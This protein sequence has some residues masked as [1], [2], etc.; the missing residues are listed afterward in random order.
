MKL[1]QIL[2]VTTIGFTTLT[3]LPAQA[4]VNRVVNEYD[5]LVLDGLKLHR[6]LTSHTSTGNSIVG[7]KY[8]TPACD[9]GKVLKGNIYLRVKDINGISKTVKILSDTE[10]VS[11]TNKELTKMFVVSG[12]L[13]IET[14]N[15]YFYNY[16][17]CVPQPS[18]LK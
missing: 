12:L 17:Y 18:H 3:S 13:D 1:S 4:S 6:T 7:V 9:S 8:T 16:T 14:T 2:A 10:L 5:N 11:S 15:G